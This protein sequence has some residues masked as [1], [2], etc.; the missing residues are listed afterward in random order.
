MYR[1]EAEGSFDSWHQDDLDDLEPRVCRLLLERLDYTTVLDLGSGK[2]AFTATL[3]RPGA[4]IVG[5]DASETA[6]EIARA[7]HPDIE[8]VASP[9]ERHLDAAPPV[10]LIVA[11]QVLSYLEDWRAI[12]AA[13]AARCRFFLVSLYLP[14]D[15]IGFVKSHAELE[16]EL[17]RHFRPV[18]TV[19][20]ASRSIGIH[21]VES[22]SQPSP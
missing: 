9:L 6:V 21:L 20:L 4:K 19:Y 17:R 18:E 12:V 2:G 3:A 1:A 16:E 15:P 14:Q 13:C 7:R 5:V 10:D 8:W 22:V 11:K